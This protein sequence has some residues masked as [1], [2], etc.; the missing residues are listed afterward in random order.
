MHQL[1]P[2]D[3]ADNLRA[4]G[5]FESSEA[6]YFKALYYFNKALLNPSTALGQ[7][8]LRALC[9]ANRA[10]AYLR[11]KYFK[12]CLNNI[13]LADSARPGKKM[14]KLDA[15]RAECEELKRSGEQD[16]AIEPLPN[17]FKLMHEPNPKLPFFIDGLQFKENTTYGRHLVTNI[18]LDAGDVIAVMDD[19]W[20]VQTVLEAPAACGNCLM[21][22][23]FDLRLFDGCADGERMI[24]YA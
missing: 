6:H 17:P 7:E 19:C 14:P 21:V 13:A 10:E 18:D 8:N 3:T 11:L 20:A 23:N 4:K 5:V 16:C 9:Y 24:I 15:I 22:N 12:H 1:E 2:E